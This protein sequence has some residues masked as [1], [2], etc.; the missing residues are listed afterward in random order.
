M[1][2]TSDLIYY[3]LYLPCLFLSFRAKES[4]VHGLFFLRF[5]LCFG[6]VTEMA[7]LVLR[8]LRKEENGPYYLYI[9]AEYVCL[10]LFYSRN[11]SSRKIKKILTASVPVY[12]LAALLLSVFHY[13][14]VSY[15]SVVYNISCFFNSIWISLLL[16]NF[17]TG[18]EKEIWKQPLFIILSA[19]L[20]FFAGIFFFNPAYA[21]VQKKDPVLATNLR[22]YVNT[23]LNYILYILLAYG[24]IC[25]ART[26]K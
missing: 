19:L 2:S 8:G 3:A 23:V 4:S 15:P 20:I 6:L 10:V 24:F 26:T 9:P 21:T 12:L 25:S 16:F 11:T 5:V 22:V 13:H 1:F 7:V 17:D 18:I 14:F